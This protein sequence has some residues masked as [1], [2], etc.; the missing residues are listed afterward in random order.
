MNNILSK[1][2]VNYAHVIDAE[3]EGTVRKIFEY[4]AVKSFKNQTDFGLR[5]DIGT[6]Y[7]FFLASKSHIIF[8]MTLSVSTDGG[9][10]RE[11]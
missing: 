11:W 3:K 8:S 5:M 4:Y 10:G 6:G 1:I 9:R 2:V 7:L